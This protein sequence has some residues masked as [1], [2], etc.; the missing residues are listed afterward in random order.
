VTLQQQWKLMPLTVVGI[1][2]NL[3]LDIVFFW[4]Y[5]PVGIVISTLGTKLFSAT[6]YGITCALALRRLPTAPETPA[7]DP[8]R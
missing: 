5:G 8:A 2:T 1:V 3:V 7:A 4:A 6:A